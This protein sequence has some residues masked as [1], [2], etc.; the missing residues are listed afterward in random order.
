MASDKPET[1]FDLSKLFQDINTSFTDSA[2]EL[3]NT[4]KEKEWED[5]PYVYHMPKMHISMQLEL[6]HSSGTVKGIFRKSK[7]SES[8]QVTSTIEI[9]VVAVPRQT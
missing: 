8:Q 1:V 5:S 2:I 6:T 7:T 4:F 9:D 3:Q